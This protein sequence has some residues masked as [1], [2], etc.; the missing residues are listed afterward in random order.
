LDTKDD[1]A[2]G[3]LATAPPTSATS[4]FPAQNFT[5]RHRDDGV[6]LAHSE[7]VLAFVFARHPS[8]GGTLILRRLSLP[9]DGGQ[10]EL[11]IERAFF[12][13]MRKVNEQKM[14]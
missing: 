11:E 8:G 1:D 2:V 4:F 5:A 7:G 9:S 14:R 6:F 12:G 10:R 3:W 13:L